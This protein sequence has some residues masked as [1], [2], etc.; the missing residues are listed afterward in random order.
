MLYFLS[1]HEGW[2]KMGIWF[3]SLIMAVSSG[4]RAA[5]VSERLDKILKDSRV[6]RDEV[7]MVVSLHRAGQM[8]TL[9]SVREQELMIP[10]SLTKILTA[11]AVLDGL[12]PS[13]KL[14]TQLLSTARVENGELKGDLI[15]RG[16]GDPG[17]VSESMWFLV[18][19][20]LR[21]G[22]RRI[23]GSIRV[24]DT[25]F[26]RVRAD[27]SRQPDRVDRAYDAP[28]G[29]MS[30][31]WNSINVFVRP[32]AKAGDPARVFLDPEN[33]YVKLAGE[34][35]T[36]ESGKKNDVHIDRR[37]GK[38]EEDI[39]QVGGRVGL[40]SAEV[41]S[42]KNISAPE[43]WSGHVLVGFLRQRGITVSGEVKVGPTPS[44]AQLLARAESKPVALMVQDMMKFSNNFVA[45]ML[46]KNLA[47]EKKGTPATLA[48][49]ME[50]VRDFIKGMELPDA[51]WKMINPSGLSRENR[52]TARDLHKV[53]AQLH[54]RFTIFPEALAAFPVAGVDGTLKSRM[55]GSRAEGRVRAK[56]GLLTG[57]AGLAGYA[58]R[59]DGAPLSFVFMFNGR[60]NLSEDA[61]A[62]FD[63]LAAELVQ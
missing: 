22:I 12:G 61:R 2:E 41:V 59:Y 31:N 63:R 47:A 7:G 34:I 52:I 54:E 60:P 24:D 40:S 44:Q 42:Y 35:R 10:A 49:G 11:V 29:A 56:T 62:L 5:S 57:V 16:G 55:K 48:G 50:L 4:A 6:K 39:V 20:L 58:G 25:R 38:G 27:D 43:I 9:W 51:N 30:F 1:K 26:D 36:V 23:T 8:E 13:R 3:F 45:E 17:F 15:L 33:S 32:G 14:E 21:T 53:L 19:E 37:A 28:V 46:V 18:N